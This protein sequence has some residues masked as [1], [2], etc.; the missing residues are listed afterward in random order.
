VVSWA[1]A[2]GIGALLGQAVASPVGT[3]VEITLPTTAVTANGLVSF[4]LRGINGTAGA[5][6]TYFQSRETVNKPQ[7]VIVTGP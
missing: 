3:Y 4:E 1:T 7:L 6:S 2:P 5:K